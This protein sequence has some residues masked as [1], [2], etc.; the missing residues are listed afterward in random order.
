MLLLQQ[1]GVAA[2]IA[3][4]GWAMQEPG[5]WYKVPGCMMTCVRCGRSIIFGGD[6]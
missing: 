2:A 5:R 4:T 3:A 1:R 6:S